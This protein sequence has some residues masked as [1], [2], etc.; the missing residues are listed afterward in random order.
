ME[1]NGA[2]DS[3]AKRLENSVSPALDNLTQGLTDMFASL[4][5]GSKSWKKALGDMLKS[6]AMFVI[7]YI[8]KC[9]AMLA[10]TEIMKALGVPIPPAMSFGGGKFGGGP[11]GPS[12]DASAGTPAFNGAY[13]APGRLGGGSIYDYLRDGGGK[14]RTGVSNRDSSLYNL[15][16]GEYVVRNKSVRDLGLPFM[17]AINKHGAAGLAKMGGGVMQNFQMPKQETNVFV[18]KPDS[19]PAMGPNDVLV[20]VHEDILQGGATKKLIKQVAQGA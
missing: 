17:D 7:Q 20:T 6:F 10:I 4:M 18:V 12:N 15:A 14:V 1:Q 8:A 13:V 2:M 19:Q 11:T 16:H 5:D 9:L 3:W